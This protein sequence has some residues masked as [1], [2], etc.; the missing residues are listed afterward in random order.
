MI[1]GP[2]QLA[3]V[4]GL[5]AGRERA[6]LDLS[7]PLIRAMAEANH[8]P[9]EHWAPDKKDGTAQVLKLVSV[10]CRRCAQPWP[11]ETRSVLQALPG[12]PAASE[13]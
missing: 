4:S 10:L 11:C 3:A 2:V 13:A 9:N 7:D 6:V 1:T 8:V 12:A 5:P